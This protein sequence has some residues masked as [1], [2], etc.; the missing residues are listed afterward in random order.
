LEST[1]FKIIPIGYERRASAVNVG[2][3]YSRYVTYAL[4]TAGR[5]VTVYCETNACRILWRLSCM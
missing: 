3:L 4:C 2:N 1:T 5:L